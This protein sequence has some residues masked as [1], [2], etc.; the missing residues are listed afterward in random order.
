MDPGW[1]ED[2]N[3][4]NWTAVDPSTFDD[5]NQ[6]PNT[7]DALENTTYAVN[8]N[9]MTLAVTWWVFRLNSAT[10]FGSNRPPIS[11][12]FGHLFRANSATPSIMI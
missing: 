8:T 9:A 11:V 5:G 12:E 7:L 2:N 3:S 6:H 10:H 1:N 4:W